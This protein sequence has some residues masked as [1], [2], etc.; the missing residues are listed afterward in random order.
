MLE[1]Y[2]IP[3]NDEVLKCLVNSLNKVSINFYEM[4]YG[5]VS[6]GVQKLENCF[7][8]EL[9]HQLR[10]LQDCEGKLRGLKF[11]MDINKVPN[12]NENQ[13]RIEC[14]DYYQPKSIR[15]DLVLHSDQSNVYN[16]ALICEIKMDTTTPQAII[17]DLKKLLYYKLSYLHFKEVVFIY[18][19]DRT[20]LESILQNR[21]KIQFKKCL[22]THNV[23]F[24]LKD[25]NNNE[26]ALYKLEN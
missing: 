6:K 3:E 8:A 20:K 11:N 2:Q 19:G 4:N 15:P 7:T 25:I 26:W 12:N 14:I 1:N 16:Q 23:L 9:Y 5:N 24:A 17:K 10:R 21:L 22:N 18:V 13:N